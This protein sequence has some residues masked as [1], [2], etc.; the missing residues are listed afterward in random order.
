MICFLHDITLARA[1]FQSLEAHRRIEQA[2][3]AFWFFYG[4]SLPSRLK[5]GLAHW[6]KDKPPAASLRNAS[7]F[8]LPRPRKNA[9]KS[10]PLYM[11][12]SLWNRLSPAA[13]ASKSPRGLRSLLTL[14]V[15]LSVV[16]FV[17]HVSTVTISLS[18]H[19]LN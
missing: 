12:L 10:S 5:S 13:Q 6:L 11:C 4:G 9:L 19:P 7:H 16:S 17:C 8:R 1:G 15:E 14:S 18:P 3:F 2:V